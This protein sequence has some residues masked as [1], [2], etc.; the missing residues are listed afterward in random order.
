MKT[1]RLSDQIR[2]AVDSSGLSRYAVC[3]ETGIDQ[4]A[5]SH[6]MAGHRGLS[7][8]SLD[9][10]GEVLNLQVVAHPRKGTKGSK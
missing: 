9:R 8:D 1:D 10:L 2:R 7:L 3:K 5:F 6:F 4:G